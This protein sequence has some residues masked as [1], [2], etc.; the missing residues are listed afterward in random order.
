MTLDEFIEMANHKKQKKLPLRQ[1][2]EQRIAKKIQIWHYQNLGDKP[3]MVI[4]RLFDNKLTIIIE[5]SLTPIEKYLIQE[6][7]EALVEEIR[8]KLVKTAKKQWK[9]LIEELLLNVR[10]VDL[11]S[12]GTVTTNRLGI[13][14]ILDRHPQLASL[15]KGFVIQEELTRREQDVLDLVAEGCTNQEIS[16][17]LFITVGTVKSHVRSI[18]GKLGVV[19]RTQ[20]AVIAL[21][22][23]L[24]D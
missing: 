5:D 14:F 21:R 1:E 12:E 23:G 9:R 20:A 22:S 24:V 4:G 6:G 15:D 7:E 8:L 19:D 13:V 10:V 2:L 3:K 17:R 18:I 16:E 11:I